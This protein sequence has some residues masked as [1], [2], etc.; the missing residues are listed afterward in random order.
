M[1]NPEYVAGVTAIY[2]KYIDMYFD[3]PESYSVDKNDLKM[4]ETVNDE[5]EPLGL[6]FEYSGD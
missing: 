5:L 4:I 6:H 3:A 1:K 2:R